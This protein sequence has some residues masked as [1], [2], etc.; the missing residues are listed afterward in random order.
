MTSPLASIV[1]NIGYFSPDDLGL[2]G[3]G[4]EPGL[5]ER[6]GAVVL[7]LLLG[8]DDVRVRRVQVQLR[9]HLVERERRQLPQ[10]GEGRSYGALRGHTGII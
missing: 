3:G 9:L 2:G 10:E 6:P 5:N 8:P 4:L 7:G 1:S